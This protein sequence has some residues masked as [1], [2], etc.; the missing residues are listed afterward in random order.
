[1]GKAEGLIR[2]GILLQA[3]A[4]AGFAISPRFGLPALLASGAVLAV[5]NGFTQPSTSAYISKRAS[6]STQGG[7]LGANQ[8][9]ASLARMFGPAMGGYLYGT[10]GPSA[11][12]VTGAVGM[13][14]ALAC[15]ARL[16]RAPA[17]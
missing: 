13:M 8:S 16:R 5:G 1:M 3:V 14:I 6:A 17:V 2:V 4:F 11:P 12:Y 15:A 7:T 10:V 9:M